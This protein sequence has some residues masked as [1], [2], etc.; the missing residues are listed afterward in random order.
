[1]SAK[2]TAAAK[3]QREDDNAMAKLRARFSNDRQLKG[4][5]G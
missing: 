1:M 5:L 2:E 4:G 3:P